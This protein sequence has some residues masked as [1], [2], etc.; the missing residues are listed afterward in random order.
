MSAIDLNE[1]NN[2]DKVVVELKMAS[3]L[4]TVRSVLNFQERNGYTKI[5]KYRGRTAFACCENG[6]PVR[7]NFPGGDDDRAFWIDKCNIKSIRPYFESRR[8]W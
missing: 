5:Y 6:W 3:F 1:F 8:Y 2:G 4:Y 7:D